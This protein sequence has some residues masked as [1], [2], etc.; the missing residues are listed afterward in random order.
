MIMHWSKEAKDTIWLAGL[1]GA[2]YLLPL[3][4]W[5]YLM[6]VFG[7]E[8]F[9]VYSFGLSLAQYLMLLVDFGFNLTA[10]KQIA[11]AQSNTEETNRLFS[12][13]LCAK[14]LLLAL[15]GLLA[16]AISLLP[17][18]R[19]YRTVVWITWLMVVGNT[20]SL[21]WLFQGKGKV[22]LVSIVNTALKL[23]ILPLT[24]VLV[25]TSADVNIAA[26]IQVAVFVGAGIVTVTLAYRMRLAR[27]VRVRWKDVKSQLRNSWSVFLSNAATSTY[28]ALFV[29]ILAYMVSA[30]EVGKYAAAEKI[31][32]CACYLIWVPVSQAYFPRISKLSV[33]N[34]GEGLRLVRKLTLILAIV[35]TLAGVAL[36]VGAEPLVALLGK[37]YTGITELMLI[38]AA[39][40]A[41]VGIG[42]VQGQM[43]LIAMGGER[44]KQIFRNVYLIAGV[45]A[46]I[47]VCVFA[48]LWGTMGA[49]VA[50]VLTEFSVCIGMWSA[51]NRKK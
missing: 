6:V 44:E 23:L 46:L 45:V 51:N 43:G 48:Y 31:V 1:Q 28:T 41:L 20:F 8:Q 50:L 22:R 4:V 47:S 29:V 16:L 10:S 32:R 37:D 9:G 14:L 25:K 21:F 27:L 24:F 7:A 38:L 30:D 12:A 17:M 5:P 2:N 36:V 3:F 19:I 49:A 15:S 42:G 26:W 34:R 33:E 35:L 18:Y 11:L 40:P 13:T 39:V